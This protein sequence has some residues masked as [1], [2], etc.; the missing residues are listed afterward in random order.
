MLAAC[1]L[2]MEDIDTVIIRYGWYIF[3][4]RPIL[5]QF[6]HSFI[7]LPLTYFIFTKE[8]PFVYTKN[9]SKAFITAFQSA[10]R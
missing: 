5:A 9:M 2:K 7:V 6:V 10:S 8:T 1:I 3:T 4:H